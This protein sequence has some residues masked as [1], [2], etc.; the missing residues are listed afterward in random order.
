MFITRTYYNNADKFLPRHEIAKKTYLKAIEEGD[1]NVYFFDGTTLREREN[2]DNG[3][4][5]NSHPN[6]IGFTLTVEGL[7]PIFNKIL[8]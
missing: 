6:D 2:F 1:K 7:K 5:D 8:N 4:V 3:T